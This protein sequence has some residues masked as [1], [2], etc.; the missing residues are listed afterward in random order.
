[1]RAG[2]RKFMEHILKSRYR[3]GEKISE[4]PFSVSYQ[5]FFI[6]TEKPVIVKIYKRGT[7]NSALIKGMKQ[8][9]KVFSLFAHHGIARLLDGDYGWQ[10]F[11]YVREFI[12]G[13]SLQELLDRGEK[14]GPERGCVVADQ[15]LAVLEE[16]HA[17]GIVHGSLKPSNIIIDNQGLVKL[18]DFVI[19][20]E[21]KESML[22]K[23]LEIM[24]NARYAS[25]EELEGKPATTASD[26]YSLGMI[27]YEMATGKLA[28]VV[29]GLTGNI[30]KLKSP[31]LMS[32]EE[33]SS[34]PRYLG[35]VILAAVQKDPLLRL[36]SAS[37]FRQGLE[38][39]CLV[40]KS[41]RN[42]E[43]VQVFENI[44]TEYGGEEIGDKEGEILQDVGKFRIR[45]NKEKH[46]NWVLAVV[47]A[48]S[49]VLGLL[50]AFLSGR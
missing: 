5:G 44:V 25:P 1:M 14:I 18:T 11:Y 42:E 4:N 31:L 2:E 41:S 46:R 22:P 38:K 49:V 45:W 50:Y 3:I 10:G 8:K 27:L 13:Q 24:Q 17:N 32:N 47:V 33:V 29:S 21:I 39:K 20:G 43:L 26:I 23:V 15:V 16:A 35:E 37:E 30:Q 19:E 36:S 12:E 40:R 7:L 6:G 48:S 34:L 28:P 9:V